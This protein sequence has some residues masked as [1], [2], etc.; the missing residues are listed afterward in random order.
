M[1][2]VKKH[3]LYGEIGFHVDVK[4]ED[5]CAECIHWAVCKRDMEKFCLNYTFGTSEGKARTCDTC[6]H[7]HTRKVWCQDGFPCFKCVY[8]KAKEEKAKK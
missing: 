7:R 2:T 8:F 1:T 3:W 6:L 5:N 4:E